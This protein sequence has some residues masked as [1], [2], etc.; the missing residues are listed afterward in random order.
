MELL[1]RHRIGNFVLKIN[2]NLSLNGKDWVRLLSYKRDGDRDD[3]DRS[4]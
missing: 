1:Q 4:N 2:I 3:E